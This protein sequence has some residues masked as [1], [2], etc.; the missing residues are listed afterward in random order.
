MPYTA[1]KHFDEDI[2]RA[3]ALH[4]ESAA[5]TGRGDIAVDLARS[6]IVMAV[7]SLDAYLCDVFI[8]LLA[9]T[10][11]HARDQNI[12]V[13]AYGNVAMPV[14]SLL[15]G[16]ETRANWGLRMSARTLM[17]KDNMLRVSR[18]KDAVN[19]GLATG[20]K[21]W[22]D[23]IAEYIALDRKRL[24]GIRSWEYNSLSGDRKAKAQKTAGKRLLKRIG[25]IIQRRHDIV[26]NCDRPR[27]APQRLTTPG[28]KS[29]VTDVQSFVMILDKHIDDHRAYP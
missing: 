4:G 9:R 12:A 22:D 11:K 3:F 25:D 15:G 29:M 27:S 26:H 23:V 5:A 18:I 16:Y 14:G 19:P 28:A 6:A 2:A 20:H 7:G 1:R 21:L 10:L 17:E 24:T 8:D 13:P